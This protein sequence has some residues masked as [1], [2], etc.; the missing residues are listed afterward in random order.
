MKSLQIYKNIVIVITLIFATLI[1]TFINNS[2]R[3]RSGKLPKTSISEGPENTGSSLKA[4]TADFAIINEDTEK[5]TDIDGNVYN[6]IRI[7]RQTWMIENLKTTRYNDGTEIPMVTG[8]QNWA[9]LTTPGYCWYENE[10]SFKFSYG[11]L[12][13]GYAASTGK[14]CPANWHV[15]DQSE[16]IELTKHLGGAN[17]AGGKLKAS[18]TAFWVSPNFG[19]TNEIGF[20]ALPGGLRYHDG[21]FHDFGFSGYWWTSSKHNPGRAFFFYMDYEYSNVFIFNNLKKIGF[22]V[23][24]IRDY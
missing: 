11:A 5:V 17:I 20:T 18:G 2:C 6:T 14:L 12:Y 13:N 24:C 10:E 4:D 1:F 9:S 8:G 3:D 7:G 15:P 19:A 16:L 23:R 21:K 22:S